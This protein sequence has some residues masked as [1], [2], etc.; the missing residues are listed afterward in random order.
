MLHTSAIV[1]HA[2]CAIAAFIVGMILIFQQDARRQLQLARTLLVLLTLM[3]VFLVIAIL[4]HLTSL[5]TIKQFVFGALFILLLYMIWRAVQAVM[6]L[7]PQ[8]QGQETQIKVVDHVG[9]MSASC[10]LRAHLPL[11]RLCHRQRDSPVRSWL[12]G[13]VM[14]LGAIGVGIW[15][16]NARKTTLRMHPA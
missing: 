6:V 1:L 12:A 14:A 15:E 4:S 5:P 7:T 8:E 9:F 11:R 10:R 3:G 16:L 2:T 13:A